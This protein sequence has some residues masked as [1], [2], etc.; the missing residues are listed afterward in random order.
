MVLA[1]K[2]RHRLAFPFLSPRCFLVSSSGAG[3][4]IQL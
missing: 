3:F 4:S 2:V 1:N